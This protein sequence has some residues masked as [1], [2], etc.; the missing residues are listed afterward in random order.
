MNEQHVEVLKD[1]VSRLA[2]R[3]G[4]SPEKYLDSTSIL[5]TSYAYL[6]IIYPL[7]AKNFTFYKVYSNMPPHL[8]DA[9][10]DV[11]SELGLDMDSRDPMAA[12]VTIVYSS[13]RLCVESTRPGAV[14][15][16]LDFSIGGLRSGLRGFCEALSKAHLIILVLA[17][18]FY[19]SYAPNLYVELLSDYASRNEAFREC[20]GIS[21]KSIN[22]IVDVRS[23]CPRAYEGFRRTLTSRVITGLRALLGSL[24]MVK[25]VY[26][27]MEVLGLRPPTFLPGAAPGEGR[28]GIARL[29]PAQPTYLGRLVSEA[30][31]VWMHSLIDDKTLQAFGRAVAEYFLL[32][33]AFRD[34]IADLAGRERKWSNI[35]SFEPLAEWRSRLEELVKQYSGLETISP[36][37]MGEVVDDLISYVLN[38]KAHQEAALYAGLVDVAR[39]FTYFNDIDLQDLIS[40]R[41]IRV[42]V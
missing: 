25:W 39:R 17:S 24:Y 23:R 13:V 6:P 29:Y 15:S 9:V 14:V 40:S 28:G 31:E 32:L 35:Y 4:G 5:Y 27:P 16:D 21:I 7:H 3:G 34:G 33:K 12:S 38:E 41:I 18:H 26:E 11:I 2:R 10:S 30:L 42:R 8:V 22:D 37:R 36:I 1:V 19:I 20:K